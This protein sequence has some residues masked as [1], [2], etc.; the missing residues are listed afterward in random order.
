MM[1]DLD[2]R[3][4]A[5]FVVNYNMPE[6]ADGLALAINQLVRWPVDVY[7]ID[8]GSD[9][10]EPAKSTTV[11][12]RENVQTTCGWLS[13]LEQAVDL[14]G[15]DYFAYWFFITSAEIIGDDD[16]LTPMARL[17]MNDPQ[18]VG[19]HP[20][21]TGDSTTAWDHL[22]WRGTDEPRQTWMI[23]NIAS[24][25]RAKWFDR[26][27]RFDEELIY[28]WGIDLET[29]WKARKLGY[30]LWVDERVQ[31]KK[32]TDIGYA[33]GRMGMSAEERRRLASENMADVLRWKYGDDWTW[34]M[35]EQFVEEGMK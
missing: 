10:M 4:V 28:G 9:R 2:P 3:T 7:V 8:N 19:V 18:A 31:I 20:A 25:Y 22:K 12:L 16:P 1:I 21:L 24:L 15:N 13:G 23:D 35:R 11:F 26:I 33:M 34:K 27:G 5:A 14:K 32:V 30:T 17:L 29:C 6:R